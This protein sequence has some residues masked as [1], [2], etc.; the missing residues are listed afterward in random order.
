M[1]VG[2]Q[3][4]ESELDTHGSFATTTSGG[5]MKPLFKT[6]RDMV[7][8]EKPSGILKKYDVALYKHKGNYILH[9]VIAV[10]D[11]F[12][13]IRGDNT[14]VRERVPHTDVIGILVAFNRKG[15]SYK[16]TDSSYKLYSRLWHLIYPLRYLIR[17]CYL[18]LRK[19]HHIFTK[20]N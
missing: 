8:I 12:Y 6:H 4:I 7:V 16:V 13:I 5:S 14:F 9:R 20:K 15:K 1:I 3:T 17:L 10:R 18:P 11:S 2:S 19:L